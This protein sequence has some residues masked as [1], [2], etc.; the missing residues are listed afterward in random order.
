M[1]L[2]EDLSE[3]VV[4][5]GLHEPMPRDNVLELLLEDVHT[6]GLAASLAYFMD[7]PRSFISN[8]SDESDN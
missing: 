7:S 5:C 8:E 1:S 2:D 6:L 3:S 4:D